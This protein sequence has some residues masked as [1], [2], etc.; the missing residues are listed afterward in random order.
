MSIITD[1]FADSR[2]GHS[3]VNIRAGGQDKH[4]HNLDRYVRFNALNKDDDEDFA[5][6]LNYNSEQEK[7]NNLKSTL[8]KL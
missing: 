5:D 7:S 1:Q 2:Q 6:S 3:Q 8:T 4:R